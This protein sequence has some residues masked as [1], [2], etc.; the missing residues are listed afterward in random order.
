MPRGGRR[1]GAGRR[2]ENKE[3]VTLRLD[4]TLVT[5]LRTKGSLSQVVNDL[6]QQSF[7]S[8]TTDDQG[9]LSAGES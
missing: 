2:P 8:D 7:L 9:K 6:A 4:S 1:E 3:T 5:Y